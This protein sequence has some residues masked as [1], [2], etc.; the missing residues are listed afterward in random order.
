ML[1]GFIYSNMIC[2]RD[3]PA[4]IQAFLFTCELFWSSYLTPLPQNTQQPVHLFY[5]WVSIISFPFQTWSSTY[6]SSKSLYGFFCVKDYVFQALFILF[7]CIFP[8]S[9]V[10]VSLLVNGLFSEVP[11][12]FQIK[13][14]SWKIRCILIYFKYYTQFLES[15]QQHW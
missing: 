8:F 7:K 6:Q 1:L 12:L 15:N 10:K 2:F 3:Q 9:L 4:N 11:F 13:L 5:L 14:C